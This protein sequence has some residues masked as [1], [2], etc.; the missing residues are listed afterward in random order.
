MTKKINLLSIYN[1]LLNHFGHQNWWPG[2]TADEIIIG[3]ILTQSVNWKNVE[4]AI[5]KLKQNDLCSLEAINIA[6]VYEIAPLIHSTIYFNRKAEKLKN[7]AAFIAEN[8][9]GNLAQM[10][11]VKLFDLRNKLLSVK[12]I[13]PETADSI[14]LY[15]G[16]L[17]IFVIDAYTKRIFSRLGYLSENKSYVE[18]Q[19]FFMN[20]LTKD[21]QLFN[22]FHAQIVMLG[23]NF[24]R[25]SKPDCKNCPL[26][27]LIPCPFP[28]HEKRV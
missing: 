22:D 28:N 20:N 4:T 11:K 17:S 15:A 19:D 6:S 25:K 10:F 3:A 1:I 2:K 9:S 23:K 18:F 5:N 27:D 12:G 16:D 24:C 8:F 21:V 13:G 26:F 7:F 14:L